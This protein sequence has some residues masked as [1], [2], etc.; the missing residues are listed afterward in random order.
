MDFEPRR[1]SAVLLAADGSLTSRQLLSALGSERRKVRSVD[2]PSTDWSFTA[3]TVRATSSYSRSS[4]SKADAE[5]MYSH[6]VFVAE[7]S[8]DDAT[9][10][11]VASPYIRFPA[12]CMKRVDRAGDS[13]LTYVRPSMPAVFS[14]FEK[15]RPNRLAA[16][17]ISVLMEGDV[18]VEIVSLSGRNPL[19][20][21]LRHA[22]LKVASPYAI[23]VKSTYLEK[24]PLNIHA[25]RHG[26]VWCHLGSEAALINVAALVSVLAR[27]GELTSTSTSPLLRLADEESE[28]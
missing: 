11:L 18:G 24:R 10:L 21:D 5:G 15:V 3:G 28:L 16:T 14:Y 17:R 8:I 22:L 27:H 6:K 25:D 13:Q 19:R 9:F 26:N 4:R 2:I 7:G 1:Y 20:S 12:D 23:R